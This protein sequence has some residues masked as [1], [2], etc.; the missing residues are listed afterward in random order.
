[1][2]ATTTVLL[3]L[4]HG[5]RSVHHAAVS[6]PLPRAGEGWGEGGPA[7]QDAPFFCHPQPLTR[8]LPRGERRKT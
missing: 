3:P 1:M 5:G 8:P 2:Y 6:L 7:L 4:L